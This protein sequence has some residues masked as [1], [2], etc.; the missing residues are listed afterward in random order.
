MKCFETRWGN[1]VGLEVV[2]VQ[3]YREKLWAAAF[4]VDSLDE[5]FDLTPAKDA[6]P[7]I[8]AAILKFNHDPESLRPHLSPDDPFNLRRNRMALE[9]MRAT[10]ADFADSTISGVFDQ[11]ADDVIPDAA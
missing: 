7:L 3:P 1:G 5:L 2:L 6:I 4:G 11:E 9:Q 8:D 10:L